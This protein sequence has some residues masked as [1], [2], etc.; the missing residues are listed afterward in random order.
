M[1]FLAEELARS[2]QA[3]D[4][5]KLSDPENIA[6]LEDGG[7]QA[8]RAMS[9]QRRL[10]IARTVAEGMSDDKRRKVHSKRILSILG[11]LDDEELL[12]LDAY[13]DREESKF[14]KLR[15]PSAYIGSDRETIEAE[16]L[17]EAGR[18]KLE[19]LGLL[20]FDHKFNSKTKQHEY[21]AF[22]KRRGYHRITTMG[23]LVLRTTGLMAEADE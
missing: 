18:L 16:A 19:Q 4:L 14:D 13:A 15:P 22:G 8:A 20:K 6:L 9:E 1:R 7:Y 12:I 5:A 17:Y 21:D 11:D 10:Y 3:V 2:G 23:K